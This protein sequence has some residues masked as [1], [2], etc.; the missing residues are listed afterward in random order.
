MRITRSSM[1]EVLSSDYVRTAR[2]KGLKGSTVL[3]VHSFRNALIPIVTSVA[4]LAAGMLTGITLVEVIFAWP[5]VGEYAV[6]AALGQD[7][8]AIQAVVLFTAALFVTANF[9]ADVAYA[10][11]DPRIRLY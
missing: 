4:L 3:W 6:S 7:V 9:L 5:G 2:A 10:V 8:F 1:L 11:A